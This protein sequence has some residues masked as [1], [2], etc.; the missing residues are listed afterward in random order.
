YAT[1]NQTRPRTPEHQCLSTSHDHGPPS[2]C[3]GFL[4]YHALSRVILW[5]ED[6]RFYRH[7]LAQWDLMPE[8]CRICQEPGHCRADCPEYKKHLQ[9]YHCNEHHG[10][11]SRNCPRHANGNKVRLVE[12][13]IHKK[14]ASTSRSSNRNHQR[15]KPAAAS[16][17]SNKGREQGVVQPKD[18]DMQ[19]ADPTLSDLPPPA[20]GLEQA[21]QSL[22]ES[23]SEEME[24]ANMS[25]HNTDPLPAASGH[26]QAMQKSTTSVQE[27]GVV[28]QP[29]LH[30][31]IVMITSP[32]TIANVD[33]INHPAL[34]SQEYIS[35]NKPNPSRSLS[36]AT[37]DKIIATGSAPVS[38]PSEGLLQ[39][40]PTKEVNRTHP[41]DE[42]AAVTK[43]FKT[44]CGIY[45]L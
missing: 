27:K 19:M 40:H 7:V 24:D 18:V 26:E 9:C 35:F 15:D 2:P 23:D 4:K 41:F 38:V 16:K 5:E 44:T 25:S 36:T 14:N 43:I 11:I 34:D 29:S 31:H 28:V 30:N 6:D 13:P 20:S 37:G 1:L 33:A 10:H 12:K 22:T 8:F 45:P 42:T 21:M 17:G 32:T 3:D 39:S